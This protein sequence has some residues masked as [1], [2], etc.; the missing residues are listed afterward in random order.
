MTSSSATHATDQDNP[1]A[2]IARGS[3][4]YVLAVGVLSIVLG[5]VALTWPGPTLLVVAI[6]FG[7]YLITR[8]IL[9]LVTAFSPH[10]PGGMRVLGIL[11]GT[12]SLMLGVI[13]LRHELQS[14][15]FL[16]IWIGVGWIIS[17]VS[18]TVQA[19]STTDQPG[20]GWAVASGIVS[21]IGGVVLIVSPLSSI[22]TLALFSAIFLIVI[23]ATQVGLSFS[24][25]SRGKK[26]SRHAADGSVS[27]AA[28]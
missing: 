17:G 13:C 21:L 26:A 7:A 27:P 18:G 4:T 3:W 6:I 20:R 28:S 10:V 16:A 11:S 24:L 8:G 25:R 9:E 23:G 22:A 1:L 15:V 14:L 12:L 5:V 19:L 2:R